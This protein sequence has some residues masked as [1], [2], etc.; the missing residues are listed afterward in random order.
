MLSSHPLGYLGLNLL[1]LGSYT[2][3]RPKSDDVL[4][5]L[6][7]ESRGGSGGSRLCDAV[8]GFICERSP[9]VAAAGGEPMAAVLPLCAPWAESTRSNSCSRA[10]SSQEGLHFENRFLIFERCCLSRTAAPINGAGNSTSNAGNWFSW[11]VS[12]LLLP[13]FLDFF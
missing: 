10:C 12:L 6:C 8:T 2:A 13:F 11:D 5:T 7:C 4:P 9:P 1:G 3:F